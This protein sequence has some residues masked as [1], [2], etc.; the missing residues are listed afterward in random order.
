MNVLIE[1]PLGIYNGWI[2]RCLLDSRE[3]GILKNSIIGH[4][5][6]YLRDGNIVNCLCSVE[7]ANLLL[8]H[9]KHYYPVAASYIE[10][11]IRLATQPPSQT[12]PVQ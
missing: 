6:E 1:M 7:D 3:Y 11:S 8:T 9:A 12:P 4:V 5:P 2:G 10:E